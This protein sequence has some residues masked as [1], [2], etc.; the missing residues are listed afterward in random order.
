MND[1]Q[2]PSDAG[3]DA[4]PFGY[5]GSSARALILESLF[6]DIPIG[7]GVCRDRVLLDVNK[8]LCDMLGRTREELVGQSARILYIDEAEYERIGVDRYPRLREEGR[9]GGPARLRHRDGH[10]IEA[11]LEGS[12]LDRDKP[13]DLLLFTVTDVSARALA[14][15]EARK[16]STLLDEVFNSAGTMLTIS[17][18]A[19]G[20]YEHVN[21]AFVAMSGYPREDA[22]GCASIDLGLISAAE[23]QRIIDTMDADGRIHNLELRLTRKDG[24]PF[25]VL[26]NGALIDVDGQRKLLSIAHEITAL[27]DAQRALRDERVFLEH[28]MDGIGDMIFVVDRQRRILRM[29]RAARERAAELKLLEAECRCHELLYQIKG[30]CPTDQRSCPLSQVW[31]TGQPAQALHK[32]TISTGEE[33]TLELS[34][35]PMF[36]DGGGIRA[37]IQILRDITDHL[38]LMEQLRLQDL[39]YAHLAQHDPLTDLPNRFLFSDRLEQAIHVAERREARLAMLLLDVDDFKRINDSFDHGHGDAVLIALVE[40]LQ[41][42]GQPVDTIARMGGDEFGVL[43]TEIEHDEDPAKVAR[44]IMTLLRDPFDVRGHRVFLSVSIGISVFPEHGDD[45]DELM[46]NADAALFRAKAEGRNNF[47]YYSQ[48][49]TTRAFERIL[50]ESNLRDALANDQLILHYQPQLELETGAVCGVEALVRWQH[51][52]M[53]MIP[54]D[55]FIA[56]AESTGLILPMGT[57]VLQQA[58]AQM[59]RWLQAGLLGA[60]TL[61]CVNV[62]ARQ[63]A[64]DAFVDVV[65]ETLVATGLS[66]ANLE[67]E[68]TE[69]V[70]MDS[71][72]DSIMRLAQLRERGLRLAVD[73]FGIGYSSL[74]YL[75]SLPLTKLKI[76]RSFV[77]DIPQD[78]N[79]VAITK[80]I[81]A[82]AGSLGLELLAEGIETQQQ[83]DFL[84][85]EGCPL[86]Q[87]FL[88]SRPL[89][90]EELEAFLRA[91]DE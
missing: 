49:L 54:P 36:D 11:F 67:L 1:S 50:L 16:S 61:M 68:L 24:R 83:R 26:Y 40:R 15:R 76:D 90:V 2:A 53:G 55:R 70:V 28:I 63:L 72:E 78:A 43:L 10:E 33:R 14:E 44:A 35:S 74:S 23:R 51:P 5:L 6:H 31:R 3:L 65:G 18:L 75:K 80:A 79:D 57:W 82:L 34:A 25:D 62:S 59:V 27:K 73:D 29:N 21:D 69:S 88:F 52:T 87:G 12:W 4:V 8:S 17:T 91:G 37:V 7:L 48:D 13:D 41:D 60:D 19:D 38:E 86:G 81:I 9:A 46:R 20:C 42:C 89:P 56:I 58:C 47:E 84:L 77:S 30:A 32:I 45:A 64:S 71:P 22:L 39:R 66:A 85:R